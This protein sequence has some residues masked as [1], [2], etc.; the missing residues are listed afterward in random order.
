M[1]INRNIV[2][3]KFICNVTLTPTAVRI[4]RNIVECK[5]RANEESG[6]WR[7]VLIETLWNVNYEQCG[8]YIDWSD[9]INRNIVECKY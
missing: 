3:C 7:R 6:D 5:Y 2:E 9:C 8:D 4:N 1:G